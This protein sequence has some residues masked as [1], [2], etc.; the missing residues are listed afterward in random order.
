MQCGKCTVLLSIR[1]HVMHTMLT[2][3]KL[4]SYYH[5]VLSGGPKLIV[6]CALNMCWTFVASYF[7][8]F[9][10]DTE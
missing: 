4:M 8:R 7:K 9:Q 5:V 2:M 10:W 1:T 6:T 3:L